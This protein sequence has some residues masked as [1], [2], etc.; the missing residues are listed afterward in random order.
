MTEEILYHGPV[1]N[2][3]ALVAAF[4]FPEEAY[5]L[6]ENM[7]QHMVATEDRKNLLHFARLNKID[8]PDEL[9]NFTSG[10]VFDD[11]FELR[12][13]RVSG[14]TLGVF[15][16]KK[17]VYERAQKVTSEWKS[18][19]DTLKALA[20]QP[21]RDYYLFGQ[22]LADDDRKHMGLPVLVKE[23]YYAETRIPRLL[24][25]PVKPDNP[26]K[27]QRVQLVVKEYTDKS[28]GQVMLFRFSGLRPAE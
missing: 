7:P 20:P 5:V 2:I 11:D 27:K 1:G 18:C 25:Y 19:V 16:G 28:T 23:E 3:T 9:A 15:L 12:W 26:K 21:P 6:L 13:D 10:R 4:N 14:K 8:N 17:E 22:M 24:H